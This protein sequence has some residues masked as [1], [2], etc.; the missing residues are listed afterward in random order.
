MKDTPF[1]EARLLSLYDRVAEAEDAIP[2]LR[3][4]VL[5]LAV[6]GKL[7]PQDEADER[8]RVS[9]A[10]AQIH[11][12]TLG[13]GVKR[14]RWVTT[15]AVTAREVPFPLPSHWVAARVND[16]G[17]YINGLAFKPSD[18][19][20]TGT[21]IIRIQNLTDPKKEF[22][23]AT[24]DFPDEVMVRDGDLLVSWSATL[25]AF[26][27]RN[28]TGVLNQHIFRVIPNE[29]LA[30]KSFLLLLLKNAIREMADSEHA[31]GLVMSHI[32]RGPFLNHVV[33]VPPL[34]EQH[35]IVAKVEELM[36]LLDRLEA[37]RAAREETRTRLTAATLSRLTE[38]DTDTP[39]AARFAQQTLPALTT[40]PDQIKTLRQTILN[41][42]VRGKLVEQDAGDEPAAALL[43]QIRSY[44]KEAASS[45]GVRLKPVSKPVEL[46]AD[47]PNGWRSCAM[48]DLVEPT[49]TISY[50][51]LVPGPDVP[52]GIPFVRAQDLS[53]TNLPERPNKTISPE[54]EA[55]YARTR[56]KGGEILLCVVGSIGKLGIAPPSWNGANIARAVARIAPVPALLSQYL[57]IAMQSPAVQSCFAEAT[58]TLAQPT[59]NVGLIEAVSIP[60]PPLAEQH[61]IVTKV[62]ELMSLCDRLER[63]LQDATTTRARL[64]EATLRDALTGAQE[65]A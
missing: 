33:L 49:A 12:T 25:D 41:L 4:F 47:L 43:E 40:R 8:S 13:L 38:A 58:R 1:T 7:V 34:A 15:D 62:E 50:G 45:A 24:G 10:D 22:N 30:T 2:R 48:G 11:L 44:R 9:L 21:P 29:K 37:A 59:L 31:H 5:D 52:D 23:Y 17:L 65:A 64:L 6:R 60:L 36:A 28:T 27:W 46:I 18:W 26:Q 51:V 14:L 55:P 63:A 35:R 42:A 54:I 61:R 57:L 56:L 32:N 19:S 20:S 39:S 3:R 16:T 53:L